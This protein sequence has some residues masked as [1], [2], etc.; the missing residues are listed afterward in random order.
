MV[1]K[2]Y[3]TN[4]CYL[5]ESYFLRDT[6]TAVVQ[7]SLSKLL[8]FFLI[9][10]GTRFKW[11]PS[12]FHGRII[13]TTKTNMT[14]WK[15]HHEWRCISYW[16]KGIFQPVML[17]FRGPKFWTHDSHDCFMVVQAT[18]LPAI[19][20]AFVGAGKA[21]SDGRIWVSLGWMVTWWRAAWWW[22]WGVVLG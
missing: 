7:N 4:S 20:P 1:N 5:W 10:W 3:G 8:C 11:H 16:T 18:V 13:P 6:G 14:G 17:V 15:I 9:G 19:L 22:G 2:S 21:R 12:P